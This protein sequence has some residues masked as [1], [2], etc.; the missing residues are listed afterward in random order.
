MS[1]NRVLSERYAEMARELVSAEPLLWHIRGSRAAICFLSSDCSKMS[2]GRPVYGEC[3]KVPA[4]WRWAVPFDF[5]VTVFEPN[6]AGMAEDQIRILLLHELMHVGISLDK[7][8]NEAYSIVPHDLEDFSAIV[9]RYG[10][11]WAA[12]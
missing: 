10:P 1:E 4:R 11:D 8:G 3:E 5:A 2:K 12:R 9:G 7:D 6:C